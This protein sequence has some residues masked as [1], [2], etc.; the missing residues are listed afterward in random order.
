MEKARELA[1]VVMAKALEGDMSAASLVLTRLSAPLRAS[2]ER[3]EFELDPDA[4]IS[5]S[6][7]QVLVSVSRG[8]LDLESARTIFDSW[9]GSQGC[10]TWKPS[11]TN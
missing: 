4:S 10:A 5:D 7:K 3:V 1:R 9:L 6:A 8:E 11:W 2:T